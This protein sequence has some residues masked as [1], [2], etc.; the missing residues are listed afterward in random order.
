M[1][2]VSIVSLERSLWNY[3]NSSV[4]QKSRGKS[5]GGYVKSSDVREC[6]KGFE[7]S[8]VS[9]FYSS[10]VA[11]YTVLVVAAPSFY[12]RNTS[13]VAPYSSDSCT[14][15]CG[16]CIYDRKSTNSQYSS[17]NGSRRI[18]TLKF[19]VRYGTSSGKIAHKYRVSSYLWK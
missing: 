6:T 19:L 11:K 4:A 17:Q 10:K 15:V 12:S 7:R 9:K 8:K 13:T 2:K 5:T 1:Q 14:S 18:R 16:W 3:G